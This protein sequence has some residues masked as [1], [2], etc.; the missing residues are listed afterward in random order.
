MKLTTLASFEL[1][2]EGLA[3]PWVAFSSSG[4]DFAFA[5]SETTF[6]TRH[7]DASGAIEAGP[8]FALPAGATIADVRGFTLG[9]DLA[10]LTKTHLHLLHAS[11]AMALPE[12]LTPHAIVFTRRGTELW[13]STETAT[14]AVML[15]VDVAT[16][17]VIGETRENGFGPEASHELYVHPQDDAVLLLAACGQDGTFASVV[18]WTGGAVEMIDTALDGSGQPA[19]LVGFSADGARVHLAGD[20]ELLTYS[21]PDLFELSSA[22]LDDELASNYSGAML[23][24]R[25]LVDA[26]EMETQEDAVMSFDVSA[27]L[28]SWLLPPFPSGMW[29]GRLGSTSLVTVSPKENPARGEVVRVDAL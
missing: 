3:W 10:V 8:S 24:G 9:P 16:L 18:A 1:H 12:G 23:H 14:E 2:H 28:G 4:T 19:G 20:Q 7:L 11:R 17:T 22:E 6:A 26:I 29:A 27:T 21:W 15:L 25:L 5:S 13:I